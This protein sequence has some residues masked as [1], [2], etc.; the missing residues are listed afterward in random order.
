[1]NG[2]GNRFF[3][4]ADKNGKKEYFDLKGVAKTYRNSLIAS[5]FKGAH[6]TYG[7]DHPLHHSER[8]VVPWN[9]GRHPKATWKA[10][11]KGNQIRK[12]G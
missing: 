4:V 5:G 6:V 11:G 2:G 7:P 12:Y 8:K 9:K 3:A 1:M 10:K